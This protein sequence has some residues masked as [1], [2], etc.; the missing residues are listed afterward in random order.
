MIHPNRLDPLPDKAFATRPRARGDVRRLAPEPEPA[1]TF[2]YDQE[3]TRADSMGHYFCNGTKRAEH[4]LLT[5]APLIAHELS[6]R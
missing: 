4:S 2:V 6:S 1:M 3:P 5:A